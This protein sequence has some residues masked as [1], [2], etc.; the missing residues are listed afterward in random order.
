[1]LYCLLCSHATAEL[2]KIDKLKAAYMYNFTKFITWERN[3]SVPTVF[4]IHK[5][6]ELLSFFDALVKTREK[7]KASVV[8]S[9]SKDAS[10]C[11]MTYLST[12]DDLTV[13]HLRNSV[14][15]TESDT[16]TDAA[17]VFRFYTENQK[18]RFEID[19]ARADELDIKISAKLLQVARIK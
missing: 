10:A 6:D 17:P 4:C 13:A 3:E 11:H 7:E 15:I 14:L 9:D 16:L 12:S 1:M 8:V 5:N 18:L 2:P 19:I